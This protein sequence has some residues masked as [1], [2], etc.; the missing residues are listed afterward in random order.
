MSGQT[1]A[2]ET[3]PDDFIDELKPGTPLMHG[4]YT[5]ERFL[6]AGGFGITYLAKD[7]LNRRVVIK[8]CF[9]GSFCRR[10]NASVLPRSR[11]HQAELRSIVK[12]FSQE[13]H[14]LAKTDH[15][16][17][18]KVHQVFDENN[19]A[20]MALDYVQGRDLQEILETDPASLKPALVEKY[21]AKV[22]DAIRHIHGLGI[23]HRD[24]APDN[25]IINE[26][27]EPILIDF[28]AARENTNETN[29]NVTRML[30]ALRVVKDGY[31]PQEFYI[32]GS[33]QTPSSDL[34]SLAASFYHV[35]TREL[36]ADAQ[37]RLSARAAG[38]PDPIKPL[39][40]GI[41]GYS[42]EFLACLNKAMALIPR[43]RM[44]T[45]DEWMA[46]LKKPA[47]LRSVTP[48]QPSKP[49]PHPVEVVADAPARKS[50]MPVLLGATALVAAAGVGV[51]LMPS[52]SMEAPVAGPEQVEAAI[53]PITESAAPVEPA[54]LGDIAVSPTDIPPAAPSEILAELPGKA[55]VQ[56]A[57]VQLVPIE[58]EMAA[59]DIPTEQTF[60]AGLPA[61]SNDVSA[62]LPRPLRSS[63]LALID[64]LASLPTVD[65]TLPE[66]PRTPQIA[67]SAD[68]SAASVPAAPS[69]V[70]FFVS[71]AKSQP[72]L[73]S[74]LSGPMRAPA[75][76]K[77]TRAARPT[78]Q[79]TA[80]VFT[81]FVAATPFLLSDAEPGR[82]LAVSTSGPEWLD[83]NARI[84]SIN[85]QPVTTNAQIN[86][87]FAALASGAGTEQFDVRLGL[88]S[89]L[90]GAA[91]ERTLTVG[92]ERHT[93]LLNGLRFASVEGADGW[94]TQVVEAP[95]TSN[96]QVGDTLVSYVGTWENLDA[97]DS[98]NTI[99][100]RE[101]AAG[102]SRFSFAVRRDGEIWVEDFNLV[103]QDN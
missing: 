57:Q 31:S 61:P 82:I 41:E 24:I 76:V 47:H 26:R 49:T 29:E 100:E 79:A 93:L 67:V 70:D 40:D 28:G 51:V 44:Q 98:L 84:V 1:H 81:Q 64:T 56:N 58:P 68:V 10:Q 75:S 65:I 19:T 48:P 96:F 13:A 103:S 77:V 7:S 71:M 27:G 14:N 9:P 2:L 15:P 6:A 35:I 91:F 22:L 5:I 85:G 97:P 90:T 23:L 53:A 87:N 83:E 30:S 42:R 80:S 43:D 74:V 17:I 62:P 20:Y 33:E 54:A 59:P 46:A 8:E 89:S 3:Q 11:A 50:M 72:E 38:D 4:Q 32:S 63:E 102:T 21:L 45:A 36:P 25:I 12:L 55:A 39:D 18:V 37:W 92:T 78:A 94:S 52:E 16:N 95:D 66:P 73:K 99:L 60:A 34:Y 86:A 101:L 88:A 69:G